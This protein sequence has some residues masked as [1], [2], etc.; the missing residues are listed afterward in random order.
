MGINAA[1][2]RLTLISAVGMDLAPHDLSP[3]NHH[4]SSPVSDW[5]RDTHMTSEGVVRV[6]L[7]TSADN[8]GTKMFSLCS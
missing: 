2:G 5:F 4:I 8:T 3:T 1:I 7:R 6:N